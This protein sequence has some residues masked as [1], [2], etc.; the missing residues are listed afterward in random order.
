M[1]AIEPPPPMDID[2]ILQP[3]ISMGNDLTPLPLLPA[4]LPEIPM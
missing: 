4:P 3:T 2:Q 1:L